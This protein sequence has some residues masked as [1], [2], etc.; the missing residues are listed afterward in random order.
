MIYVLSIILSVILS[1]VISFLCVIS[2][3]YNRDYLNI[4]ITAIVSSVFGTALILGPMLISYDN[5]LTIKADYHGVLA[6]YKYAMELYTD[7]AVI[8]PNR[9]AVVDFKYQGYQENLSDLI[10]TLRDE[11][12]NYNSMY[13]KKKI[14]S[15]GILYN[16]IVT[17][18]DNEMKV[19]HIGDLK[20]DND[21]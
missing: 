21:V 4:G 16:W 13:I 18:P 9:I 11:I 7:K 14:M 15:E 17:P 19:L 8:D 10:K 6:Q 2:A 3:K 1:V 12:A 5:Y 20:K